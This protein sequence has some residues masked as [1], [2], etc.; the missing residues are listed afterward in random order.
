MRKTAIVLL[1]LGCAAAA[2]AEGRLALALSNGVALGKL[3]GSYAVAV[4][5]LLRLSRH[6]LAEAEV[7]F[8]P[9]TSDSLF[10][11]EEYYPPGSQAW[12]SSRIRQSQVILFLSLLYDFRPQARLSPYLLLGAGRAFRR[13]A[14]EWS[15]SSAPQLQSSAN[16]YRS[17]RGWVG[18]GL[19]WRVQRRVQLFADLRLAVTP[20]VDE[21][22]GWNPGVAF[23]RLCS[24][25]R[26]ALGR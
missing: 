16:T 25:F 7:S 1:F 3:N 5:P 26:V 12:F 15:S 13:V 6:L 23:T 21:S 17:W 4:A 10:L 20:E 19:A 8:Y 2:M 22:E 11:S 9:K 18:A 24:G 14:A